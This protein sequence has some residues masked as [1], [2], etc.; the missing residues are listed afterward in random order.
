MKKFW[1]KAE[2]TD[3]I[4]LFG[5]IV[6]KRWFESEVTAKSF[7][8]D[9]KSF[10]GRDITLHVNS[11]GGDIFT[12]LA[13]ANIIKNYSGKVKC[14]IDGIAA[15]A[16]T[17]VTCSC[18]SVSIANNALMM[19]HNPQVGLLGYFDETE[20]EKVQKSL[21]ALKSSIVQTYTD[22]TGKPPDEIS[23]LLTVETWY[24]AAEAKENNFVDEISGEVEPEFDDVHNMLFVNS[25]KV[26]CR[27]F[28]VKK[29]K[30]K[31]RLKPMDEKNIVEEVRDKE[32]SRIINLTSMKT[33]NKFVDGIIDVAIKDGASPEEIQ[34]YIDVVKNSSNEKFSAEEFFANLI[35][36]NLRSGAEGVNGS[37]PTMTAEEKKFAE[38]KAQADFLAKFMKG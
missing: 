35:K 31:V 29:F 26:D 36:D 19:I 23:N 20:I 14:S 33:G 15:S 21:S 8:D 32:I 38:Q 13:I 17:I 5:E 34:K 28:D 3:E 10:G 2:D 4:F 6:S 9:L 18:D 1:N 16:A 22:K 37:E 27:N 11:S 30:N 25:L 7:A 24:T 12:A